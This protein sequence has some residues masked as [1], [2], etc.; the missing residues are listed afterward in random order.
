MAQQTVQ[1]PAFEVYSESHCCETCQHWHQA[2]TRQSAVREG[3]LTTQAVGQCLCAD[4][5]APYIELE[6]GTA[7]AFTSADGFCPAF[8]LHPDIERAEH[9]EFETRICLARDLAASGNFMG[10]W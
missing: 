6:H 8:T 9:D 10:A 7:Y 3:G 2:L 1:L 4:D 5:R